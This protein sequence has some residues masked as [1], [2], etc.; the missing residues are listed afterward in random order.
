MN[1]FFWIVIAC[2][3]TLSLGWAA[4]PPDFCKA[5]VPGVDKRC[6]FSGVN[7]NC[8]VEIDR[9]V[10]AQPPTIHV[11]RKSVVTVVVDHS[12]P[13]EVL[14]LD[15]KSSALVVPPD[16]ALAA[17]NAI[18]ANAGKFTMKGLE[19]EA[20]TASKAPGN[21]VEQII[22]RQK[23]LI[24]KVDE[25]YKILE[26]VR[27]VLLPPPV[28]ACS[29]AKTND[30]Q[31][32]PWLETDKWIDSIQH[33]IAGVTR[34]SVIALQQEL[35]GIQQSIDVLS[36]QDH[37]AKNM[38]NDIQ[39]QTA[40]RIK[41]LDADLQKVLSPRYNAVKTALAG[42]GD[43][44]NISASKFEIRDTE[45]NGPMY[46][47]Q[48]WALD[49]SNK[50]EYVGKLIY[51]DTD[52]KE[53]TRLAAISASPTKQAITTVTV[54]FEDESKWEFSTGLMVPL[55]PIHSFDKSAV[56]NSGS[57]TDNVVQESHTYTVVPMALVNFR[58]HS[59]TLT[60]TR[61]AQFLTGGIGYNPS[62]S[63]VEFGAGG[64][65]S[66]NSFVI[67]V[68]AD[69]G[70]DTRLR[71][72]FKVGQSLGLSNPPAPPTEPFWRVVPAVGISV[73]LP[74]GGSSK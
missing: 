3:Q 68:L 73:R 7:G 25:P 23:E 42:L 71:G 31:I 10:G 37:T 67:N 26:D 45:S 28:E 64:S 50:L 8:Y 33:R 54:Q 22:R 62:S 6:S 47:N 44:S 46:L 32:E 12:S 9:L 72:G 29:P 34:L 35:A 24:E 38:L 56:A 65:F 58:V 57:I 4:S 11:H 51:S 61:F 53:P 74:I 55:R 15:W 60:R 59:Q 18:Y 5:T 40:E 39:N 30:N 66:W 16:Q 69:I 41:Q 21:D 52:W 13:F 49:F 20:L 70:R 63:T 19:M 36:V 14:T 48:V 2:F 27:R 43:P 1:R 17:Y